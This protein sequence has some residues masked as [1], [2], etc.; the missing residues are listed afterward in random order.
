ML[1]ER[2]RREELIAASAGA[3]SRPSRPRGR[4]RGRR[5]GVAAAD[6]A[7]EQADRALRDGGAAR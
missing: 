1:A 7:R 3:P 6:A 5:G 2:N 4:V